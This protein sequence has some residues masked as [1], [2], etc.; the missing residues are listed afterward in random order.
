MTPGRRR[1]LVIAW[2]VVAA[3][4][5]GVPAARAAAPARGFTVEAAAFPVEP[6]PG[7]NQTSLG[8]RPAATRA[9]LSNPPAVAYGRAAA[10]DLGTIELY[11][12]PPPPESVAECDTGSDNVPDEATAAPLDMQLSARC[13]AAPAADV[14]AAARS[15]SSSGLET[16]ALASRV[17]ADGGADTVVAEAVVS[18]HEV[19]LGPLVV[20]TVVQRASVRADGRPGG[21]MATGRLSVSSATVAGT[22][23]VV[24]PDDER[25]VPLEMV[26][27]ATAAVRD[28]LG[29][30]G[31]SDIRLAQP[32]TEA[33]PDGS[34]ASVQGG[35][36]SVLFTNND[37]A[38]NYFLRMTF[39]GVALSVDLGPPLGAGPTGDG[40]ASSPAGAVADGPAGGVLGAGA[41]SP[42][43]GGASLSPAAGADGSPGAT[44]GRPVR[45]T[46][47]RAY[48]LPDPWRGWPALAAAGLAA[49]VAGWVV[50]RRLLGW[51]DVNADRYLRG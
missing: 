3:L 4:G 44:A 38:E 21:A 48:D 27:A 30:G 26:P 23:V 9:V 5:G 49:A 11:S 17:K 36:L 39:A 12:G 34:S 32:V 31:Y 33:S 19:V 45:A 1:A 28:A 47:R 37:P 20:G 51:W 22:P 46:G 40:G 29:Q 8:V 6:A 16:G 13:T 41:R 50:R 2:A 18:A 7:L 42:V 35:G 15:F 43:G 25:T 10:V 14:R 24:G